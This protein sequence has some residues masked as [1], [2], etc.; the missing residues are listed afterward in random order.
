[1]DMVDGNDET[2]GNDEFNV[3]CEVSVRFYP[4]WDIDTCSEITN[5]IYPQTVYVTNLEM[6]G[7]DCIN[8]LIRLQS[9]ACI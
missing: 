6:G 7:F 5:P 1:M 9:I 8:K 2:L 3:K 4:S